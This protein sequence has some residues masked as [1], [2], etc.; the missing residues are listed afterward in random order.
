MYQADL[1]MI[2]NTFMNIVKEIKKE[3]GSNLP[4]HKAPLRAVMEQ[5]YAEMPKDQNGKMQRPTAESVT[6]ATGIAIQKLPGMQPKNQEA[7]STIMLDLFMAEYE[8]TLEDSHE[9]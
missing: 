4:N 5:I 8:K 3:L 1:T 9:Q 6:Q 2:Q 7:L